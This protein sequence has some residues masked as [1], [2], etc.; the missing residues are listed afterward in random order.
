MKRKDTQHKNGDE[1]Y[2]IFQ[3]RETIREAEETLVGKAIGNIGFFEA[4]PLKIAGMIDGARG[5]PKRDPD[6]NLS[7]PFEEKE[8]HFIMEQCSIHW[9]KRQIREAGNYIRLGELL[10]QIAE[11]NREADEVQ[12]AIAKR[13]QEV[14]PDTSERRRGEEQLPEELIKARRIREYEKGFEPLKQRLAKL[15]A[16][17]RE[18]LSEA[19]ALRNQITEANNITRMICRKAMDHTRQRIDIYWNGVL[20]KHPNSADIPATPELRMIPGAEITYYRQHR[21]FL[22]EAA[23]TIHYLD[24][25]YDLTTE[26]EVVS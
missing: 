1:H 24:M 16:Q 14:T 15:Q 6:G 12:D 18:L 11:L 22:E 10:D 2:N 4:F 17:I 13:R 9:G 19:D 7:S 23:K 26:K 3:D 20:K 5:L 21:A 8:L 25:K